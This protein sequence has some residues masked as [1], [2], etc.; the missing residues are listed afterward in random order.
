MAYKRVHDNSD[1]QRFSISAH[2]HSKIFETNVHVR[3]LHWYFSTFN[4]LYGFWSRLNASS[5]A[6]FFEL[7]EL[8]AKECPFYRIYIN[9]YTIH[10]DETVL[11]AI[12]E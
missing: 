1:I 9:H 8:L 6:L 4:Q 7:M 5:K 2:D 11:Y 12:C 10:S 3:A